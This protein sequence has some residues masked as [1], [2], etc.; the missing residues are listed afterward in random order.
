MTALSGSPNNGNVDAWPHDDLMA[1]NPLK[2]RAPAFPS[3]KA[4]G[5]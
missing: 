2:S 5:A 3:F 1:F 4:K